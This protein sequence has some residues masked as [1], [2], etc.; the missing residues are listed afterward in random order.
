MRKVIPFVPVCEGIQHIEGVKL[1]LQNR[2]EKVTRVA[3][4]PWDQDQLGVITS[5]N[6][7]YVFVRYSGSDTPAATLAAELR[8]GWLRGAAA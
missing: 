3:S 5:W 7:N 8:W 6:E 2:L 1:T 4:G